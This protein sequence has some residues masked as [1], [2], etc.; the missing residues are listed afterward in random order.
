MSTAECW[1]IEREGPDG[2]WE[3]VRRPFPHRSRFWGASEAGREAIAYAE[4]GY[5]VRLVPLLRGMAMLVE[6]CVEEVG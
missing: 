1:L 6:P 4:E 3:E 5:R 2:V